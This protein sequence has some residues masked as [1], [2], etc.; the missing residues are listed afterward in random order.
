MCRLLCNSSGDAKQ[1]PLGRVDRHKG[2]YGEAALRE[3]RQQGRALRWG[4]GL[5]NCLGTMK[6]D[7]LTLETPK[8]TRFLLAGGYESILRNKQLGPPEWTVQ[9]C[10]TVISGVEREESEPQARWQAWFTRKIS[11]LLPVEG[12]SQEEKVRFTEP[13]NFWLI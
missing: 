8:N 2:P 6:A 7:D 13:G 3:T 5:A 4:S 12:L 11:L 10:S 1:H 9:Q